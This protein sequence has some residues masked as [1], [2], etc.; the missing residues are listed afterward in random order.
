MTAVEI[1]IQIFLWP[2]TLAV[3]YLYLLALIG[4]VGRRTYPVPSCCLK[5][6][7]LIPAHNEAENIK[8]TLDRLKAVEGVD[9]CKIV[10][11]AD[12]CT[13]STAQVALG[14][15]VEVLERENLEERGKGYALEWAVSQFD[16]D[17]FGAVAVVDADTI[18]K[19]NMLTVMNQSFEAGAGAV[20][21]DYVFY[22]AQDT[23]LAQLQVI[24]N[25]VENRFFYFARALM[26]LPVLLRGTGMAIRTE[27]MKK[28]PWDS[29]SIAEDVDY[30]VTLI[31]N[32]VKIDYSMASSV[33]A[34]ATS[35]YDQS[36]SQKMR[37]ASGTIGMI[38]DR[39]LP[40][41]GRGLAK[42]RFDLI[43]L[44]F[45]F[46]LLSR[47]VLIYLALPPVILSF[48]VAPSMRWSY[49]LWSMSL[50]G[51]LI[52]YLLLGFFLVPDKRK[53]LKAIAHIPAFGIWFLGVQ[54]KALFTHRKAE[55]TRTE[56]KADDHE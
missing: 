33:L 38:R 5:Y 18:V 50:V 44:A 22:V 16:L 36:Y 46:L 54:I 32:G 2:L 26:R 55:W 6:L 40:L 10:V 37:W 13:D 51:M 39:I 25:A 35:S 43:E 1:L 23:P 52:L 31:S 8:R 28:H 17:Q 34:P 3:V 21:L 47:P 48:F 9:R 29:H 56:R 19:P 12:N 15:G 41:L 24:A 11:I 4:A 42:A 20:Q 49:L 45:S 14:E 53:A 27:V 7:I 30:A